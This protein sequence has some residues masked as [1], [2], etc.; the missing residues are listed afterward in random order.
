LQSRGI[1][2]NIAKWIITTIANENLI[3][4]SLG[5]LSLIVDN[6]SLVIAVQGMYPPS[7]FPTNHYFWEFLAYCSGTGRSLLIIGSAAGVVA[8]GMEKKS[9][10]TLR[11]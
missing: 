6:V 7:Q 8:M 11:K 9:F 5:I 10:G 1:L 2:T 4:L 3:V